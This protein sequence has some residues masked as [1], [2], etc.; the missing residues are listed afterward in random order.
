MSWIRFVA[1]NWLCWLALPACAAPVFWLS[2]S[3]VLGT[4]SLLDLT[5][6]PNSTGQLHIWASSD[7]RLSGV[8]L[9]L[10]QTGDALR[11]TGATVHFP[12]DRWVIGSTPT[13]TDSAVRSLDGGCSGGGISCSGIG[14][15]SPEGTT[16]LYATVDY[17]VS[18]DCCSSSL[19]FQV[20]NLT[21]VDWDGNY[22]N[23]HF[24]TATSSAIPGHLIGGTGFVGTVH[25][26]PEPA[27]LLL[28]ALAIASVASSRRRVAR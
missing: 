20:G 13:V 8:S 27:A 28:A 15:G 12:G 19:A 17:E 6:E 7:M 1:L 25:V 5:V 21:I 26:I 3:A 4:P 11:F 24:G 9:N 23:V 14:A 18:G 2:D 16:V 10:L 22:P